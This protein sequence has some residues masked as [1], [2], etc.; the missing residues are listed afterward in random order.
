MNCRLRIWDC[1]LKVIYLKFILKLFSSVMKGIYFILTLFVFLFGCLK[2]PDK[3]TIN[4]EKII[5]AE[6]PILYEGCNLKAG[7]TV[8]IHKQT[9]LDSV[10][11]KDLISLTP[12]LQNID[13]TR[14]DVLAGSEG[15]TRG[16][17]A[18]E[19]HLIQNE[20]TIYTYTLYIHYDLTMVAGKFYY[21]II[22]DKLPEGSH[23]I[24]DINIVGQ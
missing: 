5:P 23:V 11:T 22:I 19:H 9:T 20:S 2:E 17:D 10:Y 14:F 15:F 1:G 21:G 12:E 8:V 7:S 6:L 16:I 13:F 24:F 4:I 18:L 3:G